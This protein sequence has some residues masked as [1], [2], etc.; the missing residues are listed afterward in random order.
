MNKV[1]KVQYAQKRRA[2]KKGLDTHSLWCTSSATIIPS[3]GATVANYVSQ[4]FALMD[5]SGPLGFAN[6]ADFAVYRLLYDRVRI[7][8]VRVRIVPK[9]NVLSQNSAQEDYA[10]N[11]TGEGL[12]HTAIDR[13]GPIPL[14]GTEALNTIRRYGSHKSY[15]VMKPF[16]RSYAIKYPKGVWFDSSNIFED[17]TL[18]RRL[19]G[20]GGVQI[21]AE[22]FLEDNGEIINEPWAAVEVSYHVVFMGKKPATVGLAP[23]GG[24]TLSEPE[25]G[26]L[27]TSSG[28]SRVTGTLHDTDYAPT[29]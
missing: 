17:T 7:N 21:Y 27:L 16:T 10:Y 26:T 15:S 18:I 5:P 20:T 6:N 14:S 29:S 9:A 8:S 13:D 19:G 25:L 23:G 11:A 2:F 24:L 3:Q 4:F 12:V 1:K 28:L 22:N